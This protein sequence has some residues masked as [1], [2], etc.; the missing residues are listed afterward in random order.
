MAVMAIFRKFLY[1]FRSVSCL[2]AATW[3]AIGE[4]QEELYCKSNQKSQ[5]NEI[6]ARISTFR[7]ESPVSFHLEL[8]PLYL[9]LLLHQR[10]GNYLWIV[11]PQP[12]IEFAFLSDYMPGHIMKITVGILRRIES[13]LPY[14][15]AKW[16][17]Y[18]PYIS[19]SAQK[20]IEYIALKFVNTYSCHI[21]QPH[22][23]F[24]RC[25]MSG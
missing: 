9:F 8:A 25:R 21:K 12:W 20:K 6:A 23:R 1:I 17:A 19:L 11:I 5:H 15:F 10:I 4:A 7:D 24:N 18:C 2:M 22:F 13:Y 14:R 16:V 3:R